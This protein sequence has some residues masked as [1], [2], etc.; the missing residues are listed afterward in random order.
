[1]SLPSS[2]QL[3]LL[4]V[5]LPL[6]GLAGRAA[7]RPVT[8]RATDSAA[9]P[10]LTSDLILTALGSLGIGELNKG[11][12]R[13]DGVRFPGPITR[14]GPGWR[15]DVDLPPG[16]TAGDVIERRDRLASGLRRPLG[17][18]WPEVDPDIHAGRLVLW[19]GDRPLATGK[20]VAWPLTKTGRTNIF[21]PVPLGLDQRGRPVTVTLMFA[22]GVVGAIPRM[23]KTFV[24]RLLTL[25]GALDP[26]VEVHAY[27]LKGGSD[28]DPLA[29]V[30]HAY[31]TGD[32]EETSLTCSGT[33]VPWPRTA[34]GATRCS[35]PCLATCAR[36]PRS[37]TSSPADGTSAAPGP[38]RHRRVPARVRA[39]RPRRGADG[40]G[41]R[42]RQ[43]RPGGRDHGVVRHTAA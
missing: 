27:N 41:D 38:A 35:A 42:P 8:S 2:L 21:E 18:V 14:D 9:V 13:G 24:M 4:A 29:T 19:V 10:R 30:A 20:P 3:A 36:S 7:D 25:A 26:R 11:L 31:R 23:G 12:T 22:S 40:P 17:C 32:D 28:F 15:A 33:S 37:P 43:G 39:P 1:V 6:L 34:A 16:V 5:V